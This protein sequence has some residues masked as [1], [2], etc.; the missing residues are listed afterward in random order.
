MSD[1][2]ATPGSGYLVKSLSPGAEAVVVCVSAPSLIQEII[3]RQ[4]G[5]R[6]PESLV[7]ISKAALAAILIQGL[8]DINLSEQISLQWKMDGSI[9]NIYADSMNHGVVRATMTQSTPAA[10]VSSGEGSHGIFQL[11]RVRGELKASGIVTSNGNINE[12]IQD[13]MLQ[14]EQKT[15]AV[16]LAV[17]FGVE[18]L[19]SGEEKLI[20]SS[21]RGY[22]VHV[23]PELDEAKRELLLK[24]WHKQL[25][26]LGGPSQWALSDDDKESCYEMVNLVC[27]SDQSKLIFEY[28]LKFECTCSEEKVRKA[29]QLSDEALA[30]Q[31]VVPQDEG[32][33]LEIT[34][35]YCGKV[36][37]VPTVTA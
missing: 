23:L 21:A 37:L 16:G 3:E 10:S 22:L 36:Y 27:F 5:F 26:A 8:N 35:H 30:Q 7:N 28:P 32:D 20:V 1:I 15:C 33:F 6:Q 25:F 14:S 34:C 24:R 11:R 2:D 12:D 18:K 9:E 13:Y 19:A 31:G 17:Q 4:S 29:V